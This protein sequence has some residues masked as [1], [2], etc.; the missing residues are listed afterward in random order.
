MPLEQIPLFE[1]S[2][3]PGKA[4]LIETAEEKTVREAAEAK[5]AFA[6]MREVVQN[7]PSWTDLRRSGQVA[8][9]RNRHSRKLRGGSEQGTEF[10]E[11]PVGGWIKEH[12]ARQDARAEQF[13]TDTDR[14][15]L[16]AK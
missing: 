4:V 9:E 10:N 12:E 3:R 14:P 11:S 13:G 8:D 15:D 16:T 5:A 2:R 1:E 6:H 7:A